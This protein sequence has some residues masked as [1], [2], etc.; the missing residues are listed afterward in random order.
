MNE[1][2]TDVQ[3]VE[4]DPRAGI[5]N[6][7][8]RL[9]VQAAMLYYQD[10]LT[11]LEI[12]EKLGYSRIKI[13]RVL[14]LAREIGILEIRIKVPP[15]WHLELENNLLRTFGLRDAVVVTSASEGRPLESALAA[16]AAT[17]LSQRLEPGMRVGFGIGRTLSRLPETFHLDQPVNCTFIEV[18]GTVYAEEWDRLDVTSRMAQ[19][20]GGTRE[21][22]HSPGVVTDPD[23]GVLL[24]KEPSVVAALNRARES[25]I[26]IQSVGPVD[27]S[28]IL[29]QSGVLGP[30]DLEELRSRGAVGDAL[31]YY[32]DIDGHRV[33][34]R[35]DSNLIGIDL[36]ALKRVPR[37]VVVAGGAR[38]IEPILGALRGGY[39]NVL[40]TD[41]TTAGS[42]LQSN[43]GTDR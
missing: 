18:V 43:A 13:N 12:G 22:L 26:I 14:S 35:T 42:L 31:A 6:A 3:M 39:F 28:A 7:D 25:D 27:T 1:Q 4:A 8:Y 11:Q 19:L 20:A 41:E 21:I 29:F 5:S 36:E 10:G 33:P 9:C 30:D 38:K 15:D 40:I 2:R 34:C 16:G 17:W 24:A 37:S 32:Y 23:L